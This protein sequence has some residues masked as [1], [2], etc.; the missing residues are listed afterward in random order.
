MVHKKLLAI[1]WPSLRNGLLCIMHAWLVRVAVH[2]WSCCRSRLIGMKPMMQAAYPV[3][4]ER[5]FL[6]MEAQL[7]THE[8]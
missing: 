5:L 6:H 4:R 1:S 3:I 2:I 8:V 7:C